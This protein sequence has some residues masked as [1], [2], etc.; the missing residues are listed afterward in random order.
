[1]PHLVARWIEVTVLIVVALYLVRPRRK[2]PTH[3]V[4]SGDAALL[5]RRLLAQCPK[6]PTTIPPR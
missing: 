2:P 3:P 6:G 4:P 1:M 5:L